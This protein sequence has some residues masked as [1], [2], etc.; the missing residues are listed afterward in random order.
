MSLRLDAMDEK[1]QSTRPPTGRKIARP[2][3][4]AHLR[5]VR[6]VNDDSAADA[7]LNAKDAHEHT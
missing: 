3:V 7:A 6:P 1:Y 5:T 4:R 2:H